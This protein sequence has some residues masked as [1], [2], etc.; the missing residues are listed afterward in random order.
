VSPDP[1][2][3]HVNRT[4]RTIEHAALM[5]RTF[6]LS[7]SNCRHDR[8][9]DAV[10]LWWL[11]YRRRWADGLPEA[12]RRFYCAACRKR[13]GTLHRPR[14]RITEDRPI[15]DQFPYP[16]EHEWKRLVARFRS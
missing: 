14:F 8:A 7:C 10:P 15:G 6:R 9:L 4:I 11:F 12:I 13:T 1:R 3:D 16:P 2:L 5:R